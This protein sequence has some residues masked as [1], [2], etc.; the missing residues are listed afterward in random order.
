M[1]PLFI[2]P[3]ALVPVETFY[4]LIWYLLLFRDELLNLEQNLQSIMGTQKASTIGTPTSAAG[5]P[6]FSSRESSEG[7]QLHQATPQQAQ[8]NGQSRFSISLVAEGCNGS[9]GKEGPST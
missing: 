4:S 7:F 1:L 3:L 5:P 9:I 8:G 2:I 6:I